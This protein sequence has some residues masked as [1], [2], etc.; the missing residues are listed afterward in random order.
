MFELRHTRNVVEIHVTGDWPRDQG[1]RALAEARAV[2][3]ATGVLLDMREMTNVPSPGRGPALAQEL[4]TL[5]P[6]LRVAFV[7]RPDT[8]LFGVVHQITTMT[9]AE[10]RLFTDVDAARAWLT[11]PPA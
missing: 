6:G 1:E 3:N 5:L 9:T 2:P 8:A 11:A 4:P 7:V 10:L